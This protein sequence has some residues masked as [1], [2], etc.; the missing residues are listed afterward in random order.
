MAIVGFCGIV[1]D[2]VIST[3]VCMGVGS[4]MGALLCKIVG[5]WICVRLG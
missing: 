5:E 1:G 3:W 4:M 2:G